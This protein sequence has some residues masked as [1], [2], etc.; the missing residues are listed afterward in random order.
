MAGR[1]ITKLVQSA[2][3]ILGAAI[4]LSAPGAQGIT[5]DVSLDPTLYGYLNQRIIP[6]IGDSS[7]GPT[8]AVNSFVYLQNSF[9]EIY[10]HALVPDLNGTPDI[11]E[12]DEL[13]AVAEILISSSYMNTTSAG[14]TYADMLM[15][16]KEKY[17]EERLPGS[18]IYAA[19][20]FQ[21]WLV[22]PVP[23]P[24]W[25]DAVIP[26]WSFLYDALVSSAD[27]EF[28]IRGS[29][30]H[31]LTLTGFYWDDANHDGIIDEAE[32]AWIAYV[33]PW[34]GVWDTANLWHDGATMATDYAG[35][36]SYIFAAVAESLVP[37]PSSILLTALGLLGLAGLGRR[38]RR[39]T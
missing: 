16:G 9:P 14:G 2:F 24:S 36:T 35:G 7:C 18:T 26:T 20:S 32:D 38:R 22:P 8:S 33:D 21:G 27:V 15:Y 23:E 30:N 6:D 13:I 3:C 5:Y 39:S 29:F 1:R 37:E 34:G 19:Q 10:R 31:Y 28:L 25:F 12:N 11:Y 17:I 4:L